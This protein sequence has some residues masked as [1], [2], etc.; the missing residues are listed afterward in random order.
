MDWLA[1]VPKAVGLIVALVELA[2]THQSVSLGRAQA[3]SEALTIA[4][5]Q[6]QAAAKARAEA[7]AAQE[8]HP[9]DDG[10]FDPDFMRKD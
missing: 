9:S 8:A 7:K 4:T 5:A 1:L 2:R 6:I 3:T 10:G